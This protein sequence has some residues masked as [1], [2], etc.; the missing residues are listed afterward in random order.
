MEQ[1]YRIVKVR[2]GIQITA[3]VHTEHQTFVLQPY[4]GNAYIH[5]P[6]RVQRDILNDVQIVGGGFVQRAAR[7]LSKGDIQVPMITFHYPV[8]EYCPGYLLN[9]Q[10]QV[11]LSSRILP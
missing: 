5:K 11:A 4:L 9:L 2:N 3:E 1:R 10:R 8:P 6:Q 7:V